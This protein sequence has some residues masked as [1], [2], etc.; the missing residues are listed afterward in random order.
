MTLYQHLFAYYLNSDK[1]FGISVTDFFELYGFV[2]ECSK[3]LYP[4]KSDIYI[5]CRDKERRDFGFKLKVSDSVIKKYYTINF[6]ESQL[7]AIFF[8]LW[9]GLT[10]K[11]INQ[12]A[13]RRRPKT[14]WQRLFYFLCNPSSELFHDSYNYDNLTY[15]VSIDGVIH[16]AHRK[17]N[18]I[19]I[20]STGE[21]LLIM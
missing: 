5:K 17:E 21:Q 3:K 14:S 6:E 18:F 16:A 4:F 10:T 15:Q 9:Y 11:Q 13:D 1:C 7:F 20:N 19:V 12:I 8:G 2:G